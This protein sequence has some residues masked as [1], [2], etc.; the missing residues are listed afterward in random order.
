MIHEYRWARATGVALFAAVFLLNGC[1]SD[2]DDDDDSAVEARVMRELAFSG[3]E[4]GQEILGD[5]YLPAAVDEPGIVLMVHGGAFKGGSREELATLAEALQDDGLAV[6]NVDYRLLEAGGEFPGA[7]LDVMDASR[8]L[9]ANADLPIDGICAGVGISSGATLLSL[10]AVHRDDAQL[11]RAGWPAVSGYGPA[12]DPLVGFSGI[13][14]FRTREAQHGEL[15]WW[16]SDWLGGLPDELPQRYEYASSASA[17]ERLGGPAL[18]LHGQSDGAVEWHQSQEMADALAAAGVPEELVL[19]ADSGHGFLWPMD[20]INPDGLDALARMKTF[21]HDACDGG[22]SGGARGQLELVHGGAAADDG[23]GWTG[24]E[25]YGVSTVG[26][27]SVCQRQYTTEL[28]HD[29]VDRWTVS[30][31]LAEEEGD[32]LG[33]P[34]MPESGDS[35]DFQAATDTRDGQPALFLLEEGKGPLRWFALESSDPELVYSAQLGL[36]PTFDR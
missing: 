18:L 12:V 11:A 27:T 29:G 22:G 34:G 6:F 20:D 1:T 9:H 3:D 25:S 5:L 2:D 16:E 24:T 7:L 19:Y 15:P 10:A 33:L 23:Q 31:T 30:Y 4:G 35:L 14:D 21:L 32:C 17:A 36:P 13:Y 28:V 8:Y 26:G